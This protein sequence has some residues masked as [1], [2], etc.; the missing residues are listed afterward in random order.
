MPDPAI[1][2]SDEI[3]EIVST[4]HDPRQRVSVLHADLVSLVAECERLHRLVENG[5]SE[6]Q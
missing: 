4:H 5:S 6:R 2:P 1:I 3:R